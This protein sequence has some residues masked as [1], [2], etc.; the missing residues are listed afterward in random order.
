[1]FLPA[2]EEKRKREQLE[3]IKENRL[4][5]PDY[6]EQYEEYLKNQKEEKAPERVIQIPLF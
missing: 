1:M 6:R 4:E 3:Y 2:I 5:L